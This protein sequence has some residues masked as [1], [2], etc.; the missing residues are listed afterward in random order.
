VG[1]RR[2]ACSIPV[3][4]VISAGATLDTILPARCRVACGSQLCGGSRRNARQS[5]LP[6]SRAAHVVP[7]LRGR[8]RRC[9][10][11]GAYRLT[12]RRSAVLGGSRGRW[13]VMDDTVPTGSSRL[14]RPTHRAGHGLPRRVYLCHPFLVLTGTA[15]RGSTPRFM[16]QPPLK[17]IRPLDLDSPNPTPVERA[18][19]NGRS[20]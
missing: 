4:S 17:S 14:G 10:D 1:A 9:A 8:L 16:A 6:W 20:R 15:H 11:T 12:S 19:I 18:V 5:A 2:N 3:V 7:L 13:R